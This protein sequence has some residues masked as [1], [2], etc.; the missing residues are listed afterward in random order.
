MKGNMAPEETLQPEI[1]M[2]MRQMK[3]ATVR[4]QGT[5]M[6][7]REEAPVSRQVCSRGQVDTHMLSVRLR[8][9][10]R[11]DEVVSG[12]MI[13][14]HVLNGNDRLGRMYDGSRRADL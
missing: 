7:G 4:A 11:Y 1:S 14:V 3:E 12:V 10:L 13:V 5:V 9:W 6:P 8:P 2:R